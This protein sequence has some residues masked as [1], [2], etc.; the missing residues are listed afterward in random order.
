MVELLEGSLPFNGRDD[1]EASCSLRRKRL[2]VS[3]PCQTEALTSAGVPLVWPAHTA[4]R[5]LCQG[6]FMPDGRRPSRAFKF[7]IELPSTPVTHRR[8][9]A[10]GVRSSAF[11]VGFAW[12]QLRWR[13]LNAPFQL[14]QACGKRKS[15][16]LVQRLQALRQTL[17]DTL[18]EEPLQQRLPAA[19]ATETRRF[20]PMH[21][22]AASFWPVLGVRAPPKSELHFSLPVYV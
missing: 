16:I 8:L 20:R 6:L 10:S 14:A 5:E 12:R 19:A 7:S 17:C 18:A 22:P 1:A 4:A 9:D 3:H 15:G 13:T 11:F 2:A 21:R